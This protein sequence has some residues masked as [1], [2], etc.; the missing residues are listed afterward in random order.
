MKYTNE[1]ILSKINKLKKEILNIDNHRK[2]LNKL[3]RRKKEQMEYW[4][5]LDKSQLKM[6]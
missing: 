4:E 5:K 6:F 3:K 2:E 1:E